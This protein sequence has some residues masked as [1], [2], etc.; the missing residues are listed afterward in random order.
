MEKRV[1]ASGFLVAAN[2]KARDW[3][4]T[5]A[6]SGARENQAGVD[7]VEMLGRDLRMR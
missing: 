1:K 5:G 4:V 7:I 2:G 3:V 6:V